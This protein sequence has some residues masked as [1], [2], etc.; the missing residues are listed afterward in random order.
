MIIDTTELAK[1]LG[2]TRSR[3][4]QLIHAGRIPGAVK[5]GKAERGVWAIE[6]PSDA[7]PVILPTEKR[8]RKAPHGAGLWF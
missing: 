4:I 2:V 1:R 7:P 8:A 6:V 5:V 3:A